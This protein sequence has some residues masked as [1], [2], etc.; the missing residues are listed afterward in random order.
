M[1]WKNYLV[2]IFPKKKERTLHEIWKDF[3]EN[4]ELSKKEM[5][6]IIHLLKE[7]NILL[8]KEN[9]DMQRYIEEMQNSFDYSQK[10]LIQNIYNREKPD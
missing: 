2:N 10:R 4:K 3:E 7:R 5:K 9:I 1:N 8:V 6:H